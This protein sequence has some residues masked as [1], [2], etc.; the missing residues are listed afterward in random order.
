MKRSSLFC[1]ITLLGLAAVASAETLAAER[2][3]PAPPPAARAVPARPPNQAAPATQVAPIEAQLAIPAGPNGVQNV[4]IDQA[5]LRAHVIRPPHIEG[6]VSDD[7]RQEGVVQYTP[8]QPP[9]R[10]PGQIGTPPTPKLDAKAFGDQLHAALKD[11]VA[12]YAMQLRQNGAPV[13]T[14]IW[15]W[16]QTPADGSQGWTLDRRMHIAS[17]SKLVTAMAMTKLLAAKNISPDAK[18]I[19]Y[20]P[21][22]WQKGPGIANIS[23][24]QLLTHT[25]GFSTGGSATDYQTMKARVAQGVGGNGYDY[26]NLNFGL[27][28]ILIAIIN[29]NVS[30]NMLIPQPLTDPLWDG[31]TVAAYEQYMQ[32]NVFAPAGVT[33]ATLE[34]PANGTLAYNFPVIQAGWNSGSLES[35]SGGAG[36]HMSVNELLA[37]MGTF[38]RGGSIMS[39]GNASNMLAAGFGIDLTLN[40]LAGPLYNKNGL[41]RDNQQRT[42]QSLAYFL[43]ENMELVVFANSPIGANA[44][45]FRTLVTNIYLANLK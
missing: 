41:W 40:T 42:E 11:S 29:G 45:F 36:W 43:P 26:E 44:Q 3:A 27:C 10:G 1:S 6:V 33:G 8:P 13:Y 32:A 12:G 37:V 16:S 18:I 17:V 4:R 39:P 14:L 30:K 28:R 22:Y 25:S 2:V 24:A 19:N 20:L 31:I 35:V 38:R 34:R 23:F 5:R 7:G 9:A 21:T 15:N